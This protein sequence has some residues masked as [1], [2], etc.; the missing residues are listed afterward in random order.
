[1]FEKLKAF[2]LAIPLFFVGV[3]LMALMDEAAKAEEKKKR[4]KQ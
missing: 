4:Q 1:M 2:I 3:I